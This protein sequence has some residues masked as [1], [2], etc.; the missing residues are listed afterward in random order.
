[1]SAEGVRRDLL[2]RGAKFVL[3]PVDCG[4]LPSLHCASGTGGNLSGIKRRCSNYRHLLILTYY[5]GWGA[6]HPHFSAFEFATSFLFPIHIS[7]KRC[8][9]CLYQHS[10]E[11]NGWK[12]EGRIAVPLNLLCGAGQ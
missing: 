8:D 4:H 11:L 12:N 5:E 7:P 1:M 10:C 3:L 9:D 2:L 6:R